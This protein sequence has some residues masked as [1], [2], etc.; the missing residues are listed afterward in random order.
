MVFQR[1]FAGFSMRGGLDGLV[2][3]AA[4]KP[5]NMLADD[6]PERLSPPKFI[7]IQWPPEAIAWSV[8]RLEQ[9]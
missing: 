3:H 8:A 2:S 7:G 6:I 9:V 5:I 4:S 1:R